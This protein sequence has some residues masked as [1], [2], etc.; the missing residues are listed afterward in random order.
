[1]NLPLLR[2]K[3]FEP[4]KVWRSKSPLI[5]YW[6]I[7]EKTQYLSLEQ[8]KDIQWRR[9]RKLW[10][11]LWQ[12]NE[13][14][15]RKF[16]EAGLDQE[17]LQTPE[18]IIKL[19]FLSKKDV[20]NN[21]RSMISMGY[22]M[23]RLLQFKTGGSTGKALE[24]Y[25]DESCSELRNA[26]ARRHDRWTGWEP[27]EP[28]G[29]AWGNPKIPHTLKDKLR[30]KLFQPYI[31]LDTMAVEN[32]SVIRFAEE[33]ERVKP[34]LL[35]GHAHSL[36]ILAQ[37]VE[38]LGIDSIKPAGIISTSMM[39][40]PHERKF[41]EDVFRVKLT[42]RYGCEEVSLIG[43]ECEAHSGMHMNIE[44][45][46]IEFVKEDGTNAEPNETGQIVV[47]DLMNLAMPFVRYRIEDVGAYLDRQCTCGRGLPLM[48][49]VS[50]RVSDFLIKH[51]GTKVAGI[52]LIENTLTKMPGIDQMQ[53]IQNSID[54]FL[55]KIVPG[56][57][58]DYSVSSSLIEYFEGIFPDAGI[59]IKHVDEIKPLPSGK[60]Q[61]SIC[62]IPQESSYASYS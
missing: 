24:L 23:E 18:D 2:R 22:K 60:Y 48:N 47:T 6:R 29:A 4:L 16:K 51:D 7:L 26:C 35:F 59:V 9:L 61:F 55:L 46:V 27:G 56:Y 57:E 53:I 34:T 11:F 8:I 38:R 28:I 25:I 13:Y 42:D 45:L 17:S 49:N 33:W 43:C 32:S 52:S 19:P 62:K 58:Y 41:M 30:D 10:S 31:Y 54:E 21:Y 20:R 39:L 40:L 3:V 1:M 36:F 37:Y 5:E 15:R 14:Y 12:R 50:G 44:H